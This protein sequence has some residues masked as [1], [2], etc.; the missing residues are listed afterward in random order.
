LQFTLVRHGNAE[1]ASGE[2]RD[3]DRQLSAAGRAD[4]ARLAAWLRT[5]QPPKR[6]LIS[7]AV[8]TTETWQILQA[9]TGWT[10]AAIFVPAL[11][12]ATAFELTEMLQDGDILVGHDPAISEVS[13]MHSGPAMSHGSCVRI[14]AHVVEEWSP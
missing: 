4:V 11:Y 6:A 8:R 9:E 12:E 2:R 14:D 10:T 7:P 5:R 13:D 3:F 1:L